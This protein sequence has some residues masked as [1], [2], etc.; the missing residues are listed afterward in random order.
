MIEPLLRSACGDGNLEMVRA[1]LA[2]GAAVDAASKSGATPLFIACESGHLEVVQELLARGAAVNAVN[3]S[4][5]TPLFV[6]SENGHSEVVLE[7]CARGADMVRVRRAW[8]RWGAAPSNAAAF[9]AGFC[10]QVAFLGRSLRRAPSA[11]A[12]TLLRCLG[13]G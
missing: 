12:K 2:R 1:L 3:N 9:F 13:G 8:A 6:A 10:T 4:G 11:L 7:L 5:V